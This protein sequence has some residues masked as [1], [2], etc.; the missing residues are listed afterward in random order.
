MKSLLR[1]LW[2]GPFDPKLKRPSGEDFVSID[3]DGALEVDVDGL[4]A[5]GLLDRQLEGLDRLQKLIDEERRL[6]G[7]S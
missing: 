6:N 7:Q 3:R 1:K 5:S 4:L 2:Y